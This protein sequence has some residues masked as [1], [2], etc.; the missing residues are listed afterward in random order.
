MGVRG[1]RE[2]TSCT[3]PVLEALLALLLLTRRPRGQS[4]QSLHKAGGAEAWKAAPACPE[5]GSG[6]RTQK[7]PLLRSH[8]HACVHRTDPCLPGWVVAMGD[9]PQHGLSY[10]AL[11]LGGCPAWL[12]STR[13]FRA[14]EETDSSSGPTAQG[15]ER[16][17]GRSMSP[18]LLHSLWKGR[19]FLCTPP[20]LL[21]PVLTPL[22]P[23]R[24]HSMVTTP[25]GFGRNLPRQAQ[26]NVPQ[27][28]LHRLTGMHLL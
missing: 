17:M 27:L 15:H 4:L 28:P 16:G 12:G 22:A 23:T 19:P 5:S 8:K 13:S 20:W 2:L 6:P 10:T 3:Q 7:H 11:L 24:P 1:G 9:V 26:V 25:L 21:W 14:R 18:I